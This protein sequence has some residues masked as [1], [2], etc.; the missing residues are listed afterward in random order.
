M[1]APQSHI[2]RLPFVWTRGI[3]AREAL[4][5]LDRNGIDAEPLLSKAG[6]SRSQLTQDPGGISAGSQHRFLELSAGK[7]E[8]PL[9]GLHIAAEA[10]LRDIGLL[11]YLEAASATVAEALDHLARYAATTTEEI[12]LEITRH[13]EATLLIF[14]RVLATDEPCRQHA[15]LCALAFIRTL[16]QLTNRDFSPT[17]MS[18]AHARVE[19]LREI[20]RIL[21]CP[22]DFMQAADT[23]V[24]PQS[25]MD[26]PIIS[27]DNRLLHILEAHADE[28]LLERRTKAGLRGQVEDQLLRLLPSGKAQATAVAEQVGMSE[29]SLRRGLAQDGTSFGEVLDRLRYRVALRYLED[30]QISLKQIAWLLGY[31]ELGAFIHAFKRWTGM[32]PGRARKQPTLSAFP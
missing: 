2:P 5:Y 24:L 26:L 19:G 11:F 27:E 10:D 23:W 28:L 30:G 6:L 25:V 13:K 12:R 18:F 7:T 9:L 20:H 32:S 14:H 22:I 4:R 29:R 31:S 15:E 3:A 1:S 17:S 21:R 16:R 8:D